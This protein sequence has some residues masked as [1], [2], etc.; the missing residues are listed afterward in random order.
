MALEESS[1]G[2][3]LAYAAGE[4]LLIFFGITL[5]LWFSDRNEQQSF[6]EAELATLQE[7]AENLR[8]NVDTIETNITR[9]Q[10]SLGDCDKMVDLLENRNPWS[11]EH[12]PVMFNCRTWSSPYLQE[13]AY[14][15]LRLQGSDLIS[16]P[17]VRFSVI[18]LYENVYESLRGDIDW[19]QRAFETS[20]WGPI[21]ARY[22]EHRSPE[23]VRPSD[24]DSF[25]ES[26]EFKN[27][28]VRHMLLVEVS[29]G[30]QAET[31]E[32]TRETL[33]LVE[34]QILRLSDD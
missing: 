34:T 30:E 27:A 4:I 14:E 5:A 32:R 13:A 28:L 2:R 8:A 7:M 10:S 20:V 21:Y 16:N 12:S 9:D 22:L 31:Q 6:R 3:Y 17:E 23:R 25:V 24:Y 29:I 26:S 19:S 1:F 11:S 33:E 15:S 18:S